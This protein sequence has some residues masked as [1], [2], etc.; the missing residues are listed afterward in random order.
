MSTFLAALLIVGS[1]IGTG[2]I[3]F[4]LL[5]AVIGFYQALFINILCWLFLLVTGLFYLEVALWMPER[6]NLISMT[7]R[8]LGRFGKIIGGAS[9]IFLYN[10]LLVA[11]FGIVTPLVVTMIQRIFG[12]AIPVTLGMIVLSLFSGF[13]VYCGYQATICT[14]FLFVIGLFLTF[15]VTLVMG[16][17][18]IQVKHLTQHNNSL[19][20]WGFPIFFSAYRYHYLI[21][22]IVIGLKRNVKRI[23]M[24]V[25]IGILL[26]FIIS[27]VWIWNVIGIIPQSQLEESFFKQELPIDLFMRKKPIKLFV[28]FATFTSFLAVSFAMVDFL[29][30]GLNVRSSRLLLCLAT[31]VPPLI[32]AS[33]VPYYYVFLLGLAGGLAEVIL[34]GILPLM[35]FWIGKYKHNLHSS[36]LIP[37]D[38]ICISFIAILALFM[39]GI[40]IWCGNVL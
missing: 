9:F 6:S 27:L 3:G 14:N 2:M 10:G 31:F 37:G 39:I 15:A 29:G 8:F 26:S 23:R 30:D 35:M 34:N 5:I 22:S 7:Q 38:R 36:L 4:P 11:F 28:I 40:E 33:S 21:P 20:L 17:G 18:D 24:A 12:I 16:G 32:I 25:I 13:I 1:C 19:L